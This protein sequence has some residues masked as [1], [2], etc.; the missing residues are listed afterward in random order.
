MSDPLTIPRQRDEIDHKIDA[1]ID[2]ALDELYEKLDHLRDE[3]DLTDAEL[4]ARLQLQPVDIADGY[5]DWI[6]EGGDWT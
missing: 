4:T 5:G 2:S 6:S 3:K 1:L